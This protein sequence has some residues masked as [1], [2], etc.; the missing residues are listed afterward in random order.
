MKEIKCSREDVTS[1]AQVNIIDPKNDLYHHII[2]WYINIHRHVLR[3]KEE[4]MNYA[5]LVSED[6]G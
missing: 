3:V 4:T 5:H 6:V 2:R 1:T